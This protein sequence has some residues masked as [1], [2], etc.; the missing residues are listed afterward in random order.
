MIDALSTQPDQAPEKV[1]D[2]VSLGIVA[3]FLKEAGLKQ[4]LNVLLAES[5]YSQSHSHEEVYRNAGIKQNNG[6]DIIK[7]MV[8][9]IHNNVRA[10]TS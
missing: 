2:P 7:V 5:K 4:T 6:Q 8:D 10:M 9:K 3:A 1:R